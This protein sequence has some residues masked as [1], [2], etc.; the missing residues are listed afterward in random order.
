MIEVKQEMTYTHD[1]IEL[2]STHQKACLELKYE[3]NNTELIRSRL[4]IL[5]FIA[6]KDAKIEGLKVEIAAL[7][8]NGPV[9]RR[10]S[11]GDGR[12]WMGT[13]RQCLLDSQEAAD[14]ESKLRDEAWET[15][16]AKNAEIEFLRVDARRYREFRKGNALVIKCGNIT[17][18]T[19]S[20][21]DYERKY[22]EA[23]DAALDAV[24]DA[25][26]KL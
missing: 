26:A 22:P 4:A 11:Y 2:V 3:G 12:D 17:L 8:L 6:D 24:L 14:V 20:N 1:S 16:R 18:F 19:G 23:L 21:P 9:M 5:S 25:A 15:V 10:G 13:M 7:Q